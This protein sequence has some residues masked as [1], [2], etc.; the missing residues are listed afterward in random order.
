LHN[1]RK[2]VTLN[3]K[4]SQEEYL[5]KRIVVRAARRGKKAASKETVEVMGYNVVAENGQVVKKF[6]DGTQQVIG[7]VAV[8]GS[9]GPIT[10]D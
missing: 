3:M 7:P 8:S 1:E 5:T 2:F 4:S 9:T 10:L 6:A